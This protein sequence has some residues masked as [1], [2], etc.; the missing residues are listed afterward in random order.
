MLKYL[1]GEESLDE[2]ADRIR[3]GTR[4]YAKRQLTWLRSMGDDVICIKPD[5]PEKNSKIVLEQCK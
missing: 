5:A 4:H 3:I 2:A 1:E